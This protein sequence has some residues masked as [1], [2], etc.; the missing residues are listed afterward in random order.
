MARRAF[1][2]VS[3]GLATGVA[4]AACAPKP[5]APT[6]APKAT[7]SS[8]AQPEPTKP[9]PAEPIALKYTSWGNETRLKADQ[10]NIIAF[11]EQNPGIKVEFI[12]IAADYTTQVLTMFAAG[13]SP[14]VLRIDAW[15]THAF[16][17]KGRCLPLDDYFAKV[18]IKPEE[19]YVEPYVQCI[20]KGKW[21]GTPRGGNG[22]QIFFYNKPMFDAAGVAYPE[23]QDWTWNDFLETAKALTK[24]TS[25][26]KV[27]QFGFDFWCWTAQES[28]STAIWGNGGGDLNEDQTKCLIGEPAATEAIQWWADLRCKHNVAPTPGQIPEG[29]GNPFFSGLAAMTQCGTW[30]INTLLPTEFDWGIVSWPA[31]PKAHV[32]GSKPNA[33]SIGSATKHTAESWE[34][35]YY[36]GG[37]EVAKRDANN[38]LWAPNTW[39]LMNSDWYLKSDKK[40]YDLSPTVVNKYCK[41]HGI[42]LNPKAAQIRDAIGQELQVVLNCEEEAATAMVRAAKAVDAILAAED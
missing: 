13:D 27:E 2:R 23:K 24:K 38:G 3:A 31:G 21:Y 12:G 19:I 41:V 40:P 10:E 36:L 42:P 35:Q 22:V 1:L 11:N 39:A 34:L 18:G 17:S 4:L 8:K 16:F 26:G 25:D 7:E 33:N 20:Y 29:M 14:D 30:A 15:D 37:E 28:Y 6:T 9:A 5:A 32:S